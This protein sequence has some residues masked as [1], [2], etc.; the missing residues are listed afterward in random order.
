MLTWRALPHS[1]LILLQPCASSVAPRESLKAHSLLG[2]HTDHTCRLHPPRLSLL[3]VYGSRF[4]FRDYLLI[5]RLQDCQMPLCEACPDL[6]GG[7]S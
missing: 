3:L 5:P 7:V 4:C 6:R 1:S 2:C